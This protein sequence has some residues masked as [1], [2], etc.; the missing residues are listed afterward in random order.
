MPAISSLLRRLPLRRPVRRSEWTTSGVRPANHPAK[1]ILGAARILDG[2][3][4]PGPAQSISSLVRGDDA[5]GL[6]SL[7][8]ARPFVGAGRARELAA[9]VALPFTHARAR[10]AGDLELESASLEMF[11]R[12][13][14]LQEN[15]V[16]RE[17]RRLLADMGKSIRPGGAR[18]QQ[19][20]MHL[21]KSMTRR[22]VHDD[23]QD[24]PPRS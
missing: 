15:S 20:L 3:L 23:P 16:T 14:A 10:A 5:K 13:P 8:E 17:M 1:R 19:G 2:L 24:R 4:D 9:N 6:S 18:R 12:L 22:S 11:G 7:L 21:Y